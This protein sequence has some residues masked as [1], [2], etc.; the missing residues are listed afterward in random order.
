LLDT[1]N[2]IDLLKEWARTNPTFLNRK[3][4]RLRETAKLIDTFIKNLTPARV[5]DICITLGRSESIAKYFAFIFV[6][7]A[8]GS[9]A[10]LPD[11][12][13]YGSG[14]Y[15][16][17]YVG[18][19]EDAYTPLSKSETPIYL[20]KADPEEPY[21]EGTLNQGS[22]LWKRL[23]EH[24]KSIGKAELDLKDF[25]YR[26]ATIQSGMQAS[27]EEFLIRLF[28]P[29]WNKEV[30]VCFGIGKHGDSASTR[31]NK[32]SP[33]D[34]MHPGRK[35]AADTKEDQASR[36][37]VIEKITQHL[38][39]NPPYADLDSLRERLIRNLLHPVFQP[40]LQRER[41]VFPSPPPD[42]SASGFLGNMAASSQSSPGGCQHLWNKY[43]AE[44]WYGIKHEG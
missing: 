21:A 5:E 8:R 12:P 10:S 30:K 4:A 40:W 13:F 19:V 15:A 34:T 27:V 20:G 3:L 22:S 35:W 26:Y 37:D 16:I 11:N 25:E 38:K 41:L 9:L 39:E 33:W 28:K 7:Q 14:V 17:Y 29:I 43:S 18:G 36:S 1:R 24:A 32:R 2:S 23:R 42:I 31:Q 6:N 44:A